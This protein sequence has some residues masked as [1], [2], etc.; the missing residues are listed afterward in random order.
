VPDRAV[1]RLATARAALRDRL[2]AGEPTTLSPAAADG[3]TLATAVVADRSVPD[4]DRAAV[5]GLAVRATD[6]HGADRAPVALDVFAPDARAPGDA[7]PPRGDDAWSLPPAGAVRVATDDPLPTGAD[8]VVPAAAVEFLDGTGDPATSGNAPGGPS[9]ADGAR[10]EVRRPVPPGANVTAAGAVVA[11]GDRLLAAG[12]RLRP[13]DLEL[14]RVAGVDALAV[15]VR[16]RVALDAGTPLGADSPARGSPAL[17]ALIERWG[18]LV[19]EE[20][21]ARLRVV[22][23]VDALD[24]LR[25]DGTVLA[26]GLAVDPGGR[27]VVGPLDG[28]PVVGLPPE[29]VGRLVAAVGLVRPA[30][31]AAL[32]REPD[33]RATVAATL[34]ETVHG[35]PGV[36]GFEPVA[37]AESDDDTGAGGGEDPTRVAT[38]TRAGGHRLGVLARA[39][40]WLVVPEA[41]EGYQ[42]G[43]AV[44]VE[45]WE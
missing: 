7:R 17:A 15:C 24:G 2:D 40:A 33:P 35:A 26:D 41:V 18:G 4:G 13:S 32:G 21:G 28:T 25:E 16:P 19:D 34:A 29:P 11:A 30:L 37:L 39:D 31:A 44:V 23:A 12:R 14:A 38:P 9:D 8:A 10:A 45:R 1:T 20:Q 5:D 22:R 42:A 43:D 6:T 3:R 36:R 27:T